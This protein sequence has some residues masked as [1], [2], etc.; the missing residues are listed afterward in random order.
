MRTIPAQLSGLLLMAAPFL[1]GTALAQDLTVSTNLPAEGFV[2]QVV[3]LEITPS[4]SLAPGE[5][6]AAFLDHTDVT[7]LF[8]ASPLGLTYDASSIALPSG[9]HE[10]VVY[11]VA[12][13]GWTEIAR[14]PLRVRTPRGYDTAR[15]DPRF[16]FS[17][18][19][20]L[21][22]GH[23]PAENV[24]TR[25][26]G[27][28][29]LGGQFNLETEHVRN[30]LA[31][32]GQTSFIGTSYRPEALRYGQL[33]SDAPKVD[34]SSYVVQYQQGDI[35]LSVGHVGFGNQPHLI[36]GF[37]SR[38]TLFSYRPSER[39][40]VSLA[41]MNGSSIVGWRNFVGLD[42]PDHRL[43]SGSIGL[44][45]FSRAGALRVELTGLGASLLPQSG[46]NQGDVTDA[47]ESQGLGIRVAAATAG[48]RLRLE[49]GLARSRY[50]NPFDVA[51]ALGDS[52][53]PVRAERKNARYIET[54]VEILQNV[55]LGGTRTASLG[56][57]F[58][59]ERV[60]PLYGSIGAYARPDLLQNQWNLRSNVAGI[61]VQASHARAEDNLDDIAS[62]L[63]TKTRRTWG[64]LGFPLATIWGIQAGAAAWVPT[65][66][67]RYDRT[68]QF[69]AGI[70]VDS[71][72]SASH[73]PDQM[74]VNQGATADWHWNRVSLG[75][76]LDHSRQ[77]NRQE[78]RELADLTN[79]VHAVAF[80]FTP[81]ARVRLDLE[82]TRERAASKERQ[83]IARTRRF[84]IRG[85]WSAFDRTTLSVSWAL[86]HAE[87]DAGIRERDDTTLDAQW[88]SFVPRLDRIGGQYFLRFS[89]TSAQALD[90]EF[91]LDDERRNW[92]VDSGLNFSFF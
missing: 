61:D 77:D 80:G 41:A 64:I 1:P 35:G 43:L 45:A 51:L 40:D 62:I 71:D 92:S 49:G 27:Y 38:G 84:G 8:R 39:V 83:E 87:D 22:E 58:R 7:D 48:S 25:D 3:A 17:L 33:G 56:L 11:F 23:F 21:D 52:L 4:R 79:L 26:G 68:H 76:R 82:A 9:Q 73:I 53:V 18:K 47:E 90:R 32:K 6:L 81:H 59:H 42:E 13:D 65:L 46:Y 55:A 70:P 10:L 44:E 63:K 30:G 15:L 72:F 5:R 66:G 12:G 31:I 86:T 50:L 37:N 36:S 16:D 20:R 88:S 69:G 60:D 67:Y 14:A 57:G 28:Q 29:D 75:Y 24:P 74:S 89:R 19:G 85:N 91:D 78:G 2:D 54:N 34:L